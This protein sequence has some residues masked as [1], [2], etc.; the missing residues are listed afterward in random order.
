MGAD[1]GVDSPELIGL[2]APGT[3]TSFVVVPGGCGLRGWGRPPPGGEVG[4]RSVPAQIGG[5]RTG[6]RGVVSPEEEAEGGRG[7]GVGAGSAGSGGG[8]GGGGAEEGAGGEA[9]GHVSG[10]AGG[11]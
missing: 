6:S 9:G 2:L 1:L 7:R 8:G 4:V 11:G 5:G 3:G 10:G